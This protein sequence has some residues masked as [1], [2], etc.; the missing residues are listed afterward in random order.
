M[1]HAGDM[2]NALR[3]A[4]LRRGERVVAGIG[5]GVQPAREPGQVLPW[6]LALAVWRVAVER[7]RRP[8]TAPGPR[9]EGIDPEPADAGLAAP[10]SEDTDGRVV[11]PDH[12]L[13]HGVNAILHGDVQQRP[14]DMGDP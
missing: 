12:A 5:I 2:G 4:A 7:R 8:G 3:P 1:R 10:R 14:G 13:R 11:S 9:V 6:S